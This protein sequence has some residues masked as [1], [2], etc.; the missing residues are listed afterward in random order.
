MGNT[1]R[2]NKKPIDRLVDGLEEFYQQL[3]KQRAAYLA[4]SEAGKT[5]AGGLE[6]AWL[7][8]KQDADAFGATLATTLVGDVGKLSDGFV[9]MANNGQASFSA[10]IAGMLQDIEK[11]IARQLVMQG[12]A[13]VLPGAGQGDVFSAALQTGGLVA[14]ALASGGTPAVLAASSP[15]GAGAYPSF[16]TPSRAAAPAPPSAPPTIYLTVHATSPEDVHAA[17][18][19][20]Q[21][22]KVVLGIAKA[23]AS[24]IRGL[25]TPR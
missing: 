3:D 10:M 17:I 13:A 24:F 14:P 2:P 16:A 23:N 7:K 18:D 20:P 1:E 22:H 8:A 9:E 12:L 25:T 5:F 4:N 15:M 19:S 11:L 21:G 6:A